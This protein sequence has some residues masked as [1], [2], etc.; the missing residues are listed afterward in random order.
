MVNDRGIEHAF[1]FEM[2]YVYININECVRTGL[3]IGERICVLFP[4]D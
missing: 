4:R 1:G 3:I 2:G